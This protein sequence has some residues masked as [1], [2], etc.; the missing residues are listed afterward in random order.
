MNFDPIEVVVDKVVRTFRLR[1]WAYD[2]EDMAEDIAEALKLIGANKLYSTRTVDLEVNGRVALLPRDCEFIKSVHPKDKYYKE[3]GN[4]IVIDKSDGSIITLNY[5]AIPLDV[6]GF[7][8]VPD[9][10]PVREAIMWYIVKILVLQGVVNSVGFQYAEQEWQWRCGSAR[11]D[12]NVPDVQMME[13]VYQDF[14]RL[15]PLKDEWIK[16]FEGI[17]KQNTFDREK[18]KRSYYYS[19]S[20][21]G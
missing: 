1:E 17:G 14:V 18:L 11:A 8:L 7:P 16:N 3:E 10:A 5:Q 4:Y 2:L 9:N 20:V 15:N 13:K 19:S 6:R 12:L 21:S